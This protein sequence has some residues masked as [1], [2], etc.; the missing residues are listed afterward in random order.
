MELNSAVGGGPN[1]YAYD[2]MAEVIRSVL[3]LLL[4]FG[5]ATEDEV[6]MD[7]LADRLRAETVGVAWSRRRTW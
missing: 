6:D 1:F 4:K 5:V 2:L 3:P 7:T